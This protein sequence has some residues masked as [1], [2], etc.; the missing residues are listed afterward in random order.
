MPALLAV[1]ESAPDDPSIPL[2]RNFH[3]AE[4]PPA[5]KPFPPKPHSAP[6]QQPT[7][8]FASRAT[9][10]DSEGRM[11]GGFGATA[12][13]DAGNGNSS[14]R[15]T[16]KP[17]SVRLAG[18]RQMQGRVLAEEEDWA[19]SRRSTVST[20]EGSSM[21]VA[22]EKNEPPRL[23]HVQG[24]P[25]DARMGSTDNEQ[26]TVPQVQRHTSS[27]QQS[28]TK[29]DRVSGAESQ[30]QAIRQ[31]LWERP[32]NRDT[33]TGPDE[34]D[35]QDL[36]G[37]VD[38][39]SSSA[40]D[41]LSADAAYLPGIDLLTQFG[42]PGTDSASSQ[43]DS[44]LSAVRDADSTAATGKTGAASGTNAQAGAT[45]GEAQ[46]DASGHASSA[47]IDLDGAQVLTPDGW[48][49]A[50]TQSSPGTAWEQGNCLT[51]GMTL[52]Y[53][54]CAA[55][56]KITAIKCGWATID[57]FAWTVQDMLDMYVRCAGLDVL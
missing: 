1:H 8:S 43:V 19:A 21:G 54:M 35:E 28:A 23:W 38:S 41:A 53:E 9:S 47:T 6:M 20:A 39:A 57:A 36:E 22:T 45:E 30:E 13:A 27:Q 31:A 32:S 46:V 24:N 55:S 25:P 18:L 37:L 44:H 52:Q 34:E 2:Q 42:D 12:D 29:Q 33:Q 14:P 3:N 7:N 17:Q 48:E 50:S 10:K 5:S 51:V 56:K 4:S 49:A 11:G 40:E 26:L 16:K 15:M